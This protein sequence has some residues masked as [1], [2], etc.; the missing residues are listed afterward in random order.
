MWSSLPPELDVFPPL[1]DEEVGLE[2]IGFALEASL[3]LALPPPPSEGG[4]WSD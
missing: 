3:G 2:E 1:A 4:G